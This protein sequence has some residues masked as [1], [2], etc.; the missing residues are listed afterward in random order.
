MPMRMG[1]NL[2]GPLLDEEPYA[3]MTAKGG[4]IDLP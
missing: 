3:I 1:E 2:T 4:R